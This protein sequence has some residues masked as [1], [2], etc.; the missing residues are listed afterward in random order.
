MAGSSNS[1]LDAI[2]E[3][4]SFKLNAVGSA[5]DDLSTRSA[6]LE[7]FIKRFQNNASSETIRSKIQSSTEK[8]PVSPST[9][10]ET[11]PPQQCN[12]SPKKTLWAETKI[13]SLRQGT[14]SASDY[15]HEFEQVARILNWNDAALM[16]FFYWGLN[17]DVKELL[18]YFSKPR[19]LD[20]AI[21]Q[22]VKCDHR[23]FEREQD[24]IFERQLHQRSRRSSRK[25]H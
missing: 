15:A 12:T 13:F 3:A 23:I 17:L 6:E 19:T 14:R 7:E 22:A 16:N 8:R 18:L 5:L 1:K 2:S 20:E 24:R 10:Q 9:K 11:S 4:E 21:D 25:R